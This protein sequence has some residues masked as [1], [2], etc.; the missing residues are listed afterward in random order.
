MLGFGDERIPFLV[1]DDYDIAELYA[2]RRLV[3][4]AALLEAATASGAEFLG[5]TRVTGLHRDAY[6]RVTGVVAQDCRW[7]RV[8][9]ARYVVGADG[10]RSRIA[11]LVDAETLTS[12][13]P[14]NAIH[15]AY[16]T[17]VDAPG[18]W[19]QFTPGVNAGMI[20]TNGD[21]TCVFV[22]RPINQLAAFR[23]DP[24]AEFRRLL[25]KAGTDIA[26]RVG[27]GVRVSGFRGTSGLPGFVKKP[28]GSGWALVGDAGYSKD[29]ISAHGISAA[30]RD[31]ELCA[32]AVD[33]ALSDPEAEV[34]ALRQYQ[35]VRDE[36]SA[37]LFR[38]SKALAQY[39][40]DAS[41]ASTRMRAISDA[42]RAECATLIALP[43]WPALAT[44]VPA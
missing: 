14:F 35:E 41:T 22:A 25:R 24:E 9:T 36:V 27:A 16:F 21:A 42:V 20:R 26:D 12:H 23:S 15:Y 4:D 5:G 2:P 43:T 38:E 39:Q 31:A 10:V 1:R 11:A 37:P 6:G 40:W 19:F 17:G 28:W 44:A 29:P 8:I 34:E 3:L 18:Y 13:Q 33:R 32:R 30:L 7:S